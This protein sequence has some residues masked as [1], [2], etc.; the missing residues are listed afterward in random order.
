MRRTPAGMEIDE[1]KRIVVD[2]SASLYKL[3]GVDFAAVPLKIV[4]DEREYLDDGTLDA[5]EMATTLRTYKGKTSTSCPNIGDWMEAYE[6][7]DEIYAITITGT[8]SGSCNAAQLAAEEYQ[9]EH[10]GAQVFV[11]DSLSAGPELVLLAEHIRAL[12][13]EGREFDD[14]CEEMLRYRH[15]THLLFSL[16]SLANLARNGRVKPAVAAVAR[17]LGIRVIGQASDAG[18]LE[19]LC[20]TRG[21]HGALERMVLEM[22]AHGL[23]NG[24]VHID[25]CC[26]AAAAERLKHMVHAVFPEAKVEVGSCGALCSYYAEYGGLMVGYEDNE[27][28]TV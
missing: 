3:D 28:P 1:M 22:K 25:H 24:R 13:E 6:G 23:T 4:T 5:V 16:E 14:I 26:N 8:L 21:E 9:A 7:A 18:D 15:H 27:A 2:S 11:L 12:I 17:M 20:K 10:P 19:V